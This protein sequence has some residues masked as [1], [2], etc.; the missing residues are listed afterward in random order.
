MGGPSG[1][2]LPPPIPIIG[3]G[4]PMPGMPIPGIPMP[5]IPIP[6]IICP[7]DIGIPI[8][9]PGIPIPPPCIPIPP[10][11]IPIPMP[12]PAGA[13]RLLSLSMI[14]IEGAL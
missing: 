7:P 8:P 10:P 1:I 2:L 5:G 9:I 12:Q 11:Y 3:I 6:G 13:V 4:I 14:L